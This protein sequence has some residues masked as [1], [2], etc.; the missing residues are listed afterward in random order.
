MPQYPTK[1]DG[2]PD[3]EPGIV[4]GDGTD[5]GR[6]DHVRDVQFAGGTRVHRSR[7][8]HRLSWNGNAHA[9]DGDGTTYDPRAVR[10]DGVAQN[11]IERHG[12]V[13]S[14]W[15]ADPRTAGLES[16]GRGPLACE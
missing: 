15:R 1:P 6:Q 9:L 13:I 5:S 2:S 10:T 11:R 12:P 3:P 16:C 14:M 4:A 8:E 7:D